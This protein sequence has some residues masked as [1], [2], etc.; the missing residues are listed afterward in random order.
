MQRNNRPFNNPR[1]QNYRNRSRRPPNLIRSMILANNVNAP[2]PLPFDASVHFRQKFRFALQK[3]DGVVRYPIY[4]QDLVNL[5]GVVTASTTTL[6]TQAPLFTRIRVIKVAAYA[7]PTSATAP[8]TVELQW[9][10]DTNVVGATNTE[11]TQADT[12]ASI[13]RYAM[14]KIKPTP[15]STVGQWQSINTVGAGFTVSGPDGTIVDLTMDCFLNNG[16][17]FNLFGVSQPTV[18]TPITVGTLLLNP[19]DPSGSSASYFVPLG[20]ANSQDP[21]TPTPRP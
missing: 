12:S 1:R 18:V 10:T 2:R 16:D 19:L 14:V 8:A 6:T 7:I 9:T 4:T 20:Y 11:N 3:E 21:L 5:M 17:I 15:M 13:D